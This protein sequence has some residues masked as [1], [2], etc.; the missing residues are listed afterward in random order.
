MFE[1]VVGN[2]TCQERATE[3]QKD[4]L[5]DHISLNDKEGNEHQEEMKFDSWDIISGVSHG[6]SP[7]QME[8]STESAQLLTSEPF[9]AGGGVGRVIEGVISRDVRHDVSHHQ[10][11][12]TNSAQSQNDLILVKDLGVLGKTAVNNV[13]K[14]RLGTDV[15]I[16]KESE[17]FIPLIITIIDDEVL[18]ELKKFHCEEIEDTNG[19]F[20]VTN[21]CIEP[22]AHKEAKGSKSTGTFLVKTHFSE[23]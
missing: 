2:E 15:S 17:H 6:D 7:S 19:H 16:S 5:D 1:E 4:T 9:S 21:L 11:G 14:V 18:K 23:V 20:G 22:P 10:E 13:S 3:E 8:S 12:T